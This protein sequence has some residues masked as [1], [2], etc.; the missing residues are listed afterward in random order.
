MLITRQ[1]KTTCT[2]LHR[3]T[4]TKNQR[5]K[6]VSVSCAHPYP[7]ND[8]MHAN[9]IHFFFHVQIEPHHQCNEL[10]HVWNIYRC[11]AF[12]PK[13][14]QR[15]RT[16]ALGYSDTRAK[17]S[18][19]RLCQL[20]ISHSNFQMCFLFKNNFCFTHQSPAYTCPLCACELTHHRKW[21]KDK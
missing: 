10:R 7:T 6:H 17:F 15:K 4:R 5:K 11:A 21:G 19:V 2:M 16:R 3:R 9:K 13:R 1:R 8:Y 20:L 14:R 18:L 12:P